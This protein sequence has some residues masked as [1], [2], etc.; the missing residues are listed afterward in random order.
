MK[1]GVTKDPNVDLNSAFCDYPTG[2]A[3]YGLA[4]LRHYSNASGNPYGKRF[5]KEGKLGVFLDMDN[6]RLSFSLNS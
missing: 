6:G 2:W 1:I 5:K 4:Q 3:F